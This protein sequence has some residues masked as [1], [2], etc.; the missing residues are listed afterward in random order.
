[1]TTTSD[2]TARPAIVALG[3]GLV[4]TMLTI[5][6]PYLDRETWHTLADH[7]SSGYPAYDPGRVDEAVST[8]LTVLTIIG[9]LGLVGW[10]TTLWATLSGRRWAPWL[11]AVLFVAGA[12]TALSA[13]L[14][15]DTSG[16]PGLPP[17]LGWLG[18]LP[19]VAGAVA[20]VVV[21]MWRFSAATRW[22]SPRP[23]QPRSDAGR[24]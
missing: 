20:V 15:E 5:A 16:E 4:L 18:M 2:P 1:M 22:S 21:V 3:V 17:L 13:L 9:I 12:S 19:S 11:A 7:V 10:L 6:V 24:R 8:W 23:R 14:V